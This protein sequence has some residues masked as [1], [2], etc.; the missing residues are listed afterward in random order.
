MKILRIAALVVLVLISLTAGAAKVMRVPEE[1]AFFQAAGLSVAMLVALGTLQ[2]LGGVLLI[3]ARVRMPGAAIAA[4]GLAVST[5]VIFI[6]GDVG[7]GLFSLSPLLLA[8]FVA[9]A[10]R[11][12]VVD[13]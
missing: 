7:F 6:N 3:F 9:W 8:G 13:S 5:I 11:S 10:Y 12:G 4:L 2:L 1:V